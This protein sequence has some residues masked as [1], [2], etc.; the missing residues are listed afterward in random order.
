MRVLL[1][2]VSSASVVVD[3]DPIAAIGRGLV[4]LTGFGSGDDASVLAP[5]ADK[6]C[7]LR[8]FEDEDGRFQ[9]SVIDTAGEILAVP[10]FTLYGDVQRGRRPDFTGALAPDQARTL[11]EDFAAALS[12]RVDGR[13][14]RGQFGAHM[15]V[16]LI[17]DGPVTLLLERDPSPTNGPDRP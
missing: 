14:A 4:L 7:G 10:Q 17:N 2:R 12:E 1:Q 8:V 5:M 11:F 13:V 6:I 16:H 15:G 9:H 3:K